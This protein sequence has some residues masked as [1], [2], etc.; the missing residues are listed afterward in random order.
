MESL[1]RYQY[2]TV[3]STKGTTLLTTPEYLDLLGNGLYIV[4]VSLPSMDDSIKKLEPGAPP[5]AERLRAL[6]T[7]ANKGI[8]TVCRIQPMI[9]NSPIEDKLPEFI[10]TLA[11]VGVK[12]V[13]VEAF[14]MQMRNMAHTQMIKEIYP[15]TW[16]EYA[17]QGTQNY[18]F[19]AMLPSWRKYQYI[20]VAAE[21]CHAKGLTLG[22]AD[23]DMRLFGDKICCCGVDGV[24]GFDN[25]WKY[26]ASTAAFIAKEKGT[27]TLAD[28]T[29]YWVGDDAEINEQEG[30]FRDYCKA[31][32]LRTTAK[33]AVDYNWQYGGELSPGNIC[34]L[35]KTG[36]LEYTYTDPAPL[37]EKNQVK[38]FTML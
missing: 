34:G 31:R 12:H 20:K 29:M 11:S 37:L 25:W 17:Y 28:M 32:G 30:V 23:N 15:H 7:L 13:V 27:V 35:K 18:G 4:Q 8:Y 1:N 9:P 19:E 24:A 21:V 22:A 16:Q 5:P 14:K 33:N 26:Q 3:I 36:Q 6:E 2:P 10:R 38:Q